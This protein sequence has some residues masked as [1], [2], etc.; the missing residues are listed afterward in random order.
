M[1]NNIAYVLRSDDLKQGAR[2]LATRAMTMA[3]NLIEHAHPEAK[4]ERRGRKASGSVGVPLATP[5]T[6]N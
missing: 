5:Q 1:E 6:E 2:A 3:H 4:T